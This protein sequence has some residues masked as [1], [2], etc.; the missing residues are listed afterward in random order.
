MP[1]NDPNL[2]DVIMSDHREVRR[3]SPSWRTEWGRRSIAGS[4]PIT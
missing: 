2:I 3:S 1:D 4:L